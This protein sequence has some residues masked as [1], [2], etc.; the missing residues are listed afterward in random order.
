[1]KCASIFNSTTTK[2]VCISEAAD[3][4]HCLFLQPAVEKYY[5]LAHMLC[6][7]MDLTLSS[8]RIHIAI[9]SPAKQDQLMKQLV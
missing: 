1:M 6:F 8:F 2:D 5:I 7:C 9:R 4:V 3:I